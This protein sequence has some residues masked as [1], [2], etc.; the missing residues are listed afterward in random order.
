MCFWERILFVE[1]KMV[2]LA[3]DD[4]DEEDRDE[5]D[6]DEDDDE[7]DEEEMLFG[8]YRIHKKKYVSTIF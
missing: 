4:E 6:E 8:H 7:D 2:I 3:E 5:D 1:K